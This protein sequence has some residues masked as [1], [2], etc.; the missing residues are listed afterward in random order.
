MSEADDGKRY[1]L[2][3]N[4]TAA[5]NVVEDDGSTAGKLFHDSKHADE[6]TWHDLPYEIL[7][8][9]QGVLKD[10]DAKVNEMIANMSKDHNVPAP[11]KA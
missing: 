9:I 10:A 3:L 8:K 6:H 4:T 5:M 7:C 1:K 11:T 2:T